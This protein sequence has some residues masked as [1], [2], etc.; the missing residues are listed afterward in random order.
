M[1]P[2]YIAERP[3]DT[4]SASADSYLEINDSIFRSFGAMQELNL[5]LEV[6]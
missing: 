5:E 4:T 1:M 2:L 3:H 6:V